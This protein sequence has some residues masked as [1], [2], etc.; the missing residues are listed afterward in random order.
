MQF[1]FHEF[2]RLVFI[3]CS[4][5]RSVAFEKKKRDYRACSKGCLVLLSFLTSVCIVDCHAYLHL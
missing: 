4:V 3:F 5:P 2:V 1:R